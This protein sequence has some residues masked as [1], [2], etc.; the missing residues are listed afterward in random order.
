MKKNNLSSK[1]SVEFDR[2]HLPA[3]IDAL[4]T[5]S[6]LQSGQVGMALDIVYCDKKLSCDEKKC[7]E[8][9]IRFI[10]FPQKPKKEYAHGVFYDQYGNEYDKQG[11]IIKES[12]EWKCLK[13]RPS[14]DHPNSS[15]GVGCKETRNGTITWEIKKA[16]EEYLHY[17]RNSGYRTM[18]VDGDGVLNYSGIP[19][20]RILDPEIEKKYWKPEKCFKISKRYQKKL[21]EILSKKENFGEIWEIVNKSFKKNPLPSGFKKQIIFKE[22]DQSFYVIVEKPYKPSND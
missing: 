14:L 5:Y 4:E 13:D 6:R 7:L 1:V 9:Y 20:A 3:L 19:N 12:E 15:F 10:V 18:A 21:K 17:E 2:K 8:N 11:S 16:I 22:T